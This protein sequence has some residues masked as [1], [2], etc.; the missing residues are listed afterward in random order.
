[1]PG[2]HVVLASQ[3]PRRKE[4]LARVV[5][6][7]L[8]EPADIDETPDIDEPADHYVVRLAREKAVAVAAPGRVVVGADTVVVL[9]GEILGKPA[10]DAHN[11][12]M[13]R[14]LSGRSHLA[15][16]GVAVVVGDGTG[17]GDVRTELAVTEVRVRDL[18]AA[19]LDW[20]VATGEGADKA[21]GY[22]LQGRGAVFADVIEGSASNVIGLP[23]P[24]VFDLL[25]EVGVVLAEPDGSS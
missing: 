25:R 13:L 22:G 5:D 19:M 2:P 14:R 21:G 24:I 11:A 4:L 17:D 8:I 23:L 18:D 1:M 3:S 16:T 15:M 9:D 20:Y 10:D 12:A 7:F 6:D